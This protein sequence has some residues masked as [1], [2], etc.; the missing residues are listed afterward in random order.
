MKKPNSASLHDNPALYQDGMGSAPVIFEPSAPHAVPIA[1]GIVSVPAPSTRHA[2]L[3]SATAPI[4]M[5]C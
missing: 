4:N 1:I 3:V 5:S 2:E